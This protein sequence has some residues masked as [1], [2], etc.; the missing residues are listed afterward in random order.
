L[1][2]AEMQASADTSTDEK[3]QSQSRKCRILMSSETSG[4]KLHGIRVS[5]AESEE[6]QRITRDVTQLP[7]VHN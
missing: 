7:F 2:A 3:Q 4:H 6:D 1:G 5:S